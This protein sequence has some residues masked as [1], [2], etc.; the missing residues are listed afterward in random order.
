MQVLSIILNPKHLFIMLLFFTVNSCQRND[1]K[2]RSTLELVGNNKK[3]LQKVL[4]YY[5]KNP[6]DSIKLKAARYLIENLSGHFSFDTTHLYLYRP[7]VETIGRLRLQGYPSYTILKKANPMLDSLISM[8]PLSYVYSN[9]DYDL[10]LVKADFLIKTIEQSFKSYYH[11]PFKDSILFDDFLEYVLPYRIKNGTC[12]EDWRS[13][14]TEP[15]FFEI[16]YHSVVEICDSLLYRYSDIKLQ[17][18]IA[19]KYPYLKLEDY[20]KSQMGPCPEKCWFN[21]MLLR[22]WG[23][24]ATIDFVPASRVHEVGHEWNLIKLRNEFYAIDPFWEGYLGRTDNRYLKLYYS[25]EKDHP[26]FGPIQF[27]KIYRETF[28]TNISELYSYA[29]SK[30]KK[31]PFL[32][33]NPFLK[34]VTSEYFKTYNFETRP[35]NKA[36]EEFAYACVVGN[37]QNWIPVDFGRIKGR[38]ILFTS[39]GPKNVYLPCYYQFGSLVPAGYPVLLQENGESQLLRPDTLHNRDVKINSVAYPR[40]ELEE[41]KKS[42]VGCTLEG[43]NNPDFNNSKILYRFDK[44]FEP[45]RYRVPIKVE[46]KYQYIRFKI[47]NTSLMIND[48]EFFNSEN[49]QQ[50]EVKGDFICSY[51]KDSSLLYQ[52]VDEKKLSVANFNAIDENHKRLKEIWIGYKFKKPVSIHSF[53]IF[54]TFNY[55]VRNNENYELMYWDYEWKSIKQKTSRKKEILFSNVPENALLM[56]RIVGTNRFSRPFTFSEGSQHW[57]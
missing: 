3:E 19:A 50:M 9:I 28:K 17:M 13:Y 52:A 11:F 27:P 15:D 35:A 55:N 56:I 40:P 36:T 8:Y 1:E 45:G 32:F 22:S 38:K 44:A 51:L 33:R 14:F 46:N 49:G 18:N 6:S 23:I 39:M 20:L 41:Y 29:A 24:P 16:K 7:V 37:K 21:C 34:D 54:F 43:A 5:S 10:N 31:I 12:L 48:L 53:E 25:K 2:L 26:L 47:K 42:F 57:W 30:N 4:D